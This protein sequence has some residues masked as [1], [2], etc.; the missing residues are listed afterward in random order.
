MTRRRHGGTIWP[1]AEVR[2]NNIPGV[3]PLLHMGNN[4]KMKFPKI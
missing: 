1:I 2:C 4:S 3:G